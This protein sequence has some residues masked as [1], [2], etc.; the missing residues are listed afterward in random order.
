MRNPANMVR[1][2]DVVAHFDHC[3]VPIRFNDTV[4]VDQGQWDHPV[5]YGWRIREEGEELEFN[6]I[7][8][9]DWN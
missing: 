6:A 9:V 8:V 4:E 2:V 1:A 7:E 3:E 5:C